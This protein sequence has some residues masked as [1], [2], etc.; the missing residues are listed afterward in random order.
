MISKASTMPKCQT[1]PPSQTARQMAAQLKVSFR[2]ITR[3]SPVRASSLH[4]PRNLV[5]QLRSKR[6]PTWLNTKWCKERPKQQPT[7]ALFTWNDLQPIS[8]LEPQTSQVYWARM[9]SLRELLVGLNSPTVKTNLH[10]KTIRTMAQQ[11]EVLLC[12]RFRGRLRR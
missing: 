2:S 11:V 5:S 1:S 3:S 4:M 8:R 12:Q 7:N 9:L 10:S 6:V